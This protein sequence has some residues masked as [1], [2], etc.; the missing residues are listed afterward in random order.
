MTIKAI[1][2]AARDHSM[3]IQKAQEVFDDFE[4]NADFLQILFVGLCLLGVHTVRAHR[5]VK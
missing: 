3:C 1:C 4:K 2:S 5:T